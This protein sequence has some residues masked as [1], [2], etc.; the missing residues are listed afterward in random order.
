MTGLTGW[1]ECLQ[2]DGA[3]EIDI[4]Y[5]LSP[6]HTAGRIRQQI[7]WLGEDKAD[8]WWDRKWL[9][10]SETLHERFLCSLGM[11][12]P[13]TAHC[14]LDKCGLREMMS[15]ATTVEELELKLKGCVP[16]RILERFHS[17]ISTELK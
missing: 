4:W 8:E 14:C 12:T 16:R 17:L 3:C 1:F 15:V 7:D 9:L 11:F 2:V 13:L 10:P 6:K 5:S